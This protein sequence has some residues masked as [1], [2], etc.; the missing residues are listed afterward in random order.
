MSERNQVR[1]NSHE[2]ADKAH[3]FRYM[4][5]RG[6]VNK[7]EKVLDAGCGTGYGSYILSQ[8]A[9]SVFCID[10][11][12][13]FDKQYAKDNITFLL[14]SLDKVEKEDIELFGPDVTVCFEAI[15]H[16]ESPKI[17][18]D[19]VTA[20]TKRM[21]IFSSPDKPTKHE[22]H[23]HKHDILMTTFQEM[24][25][26]Y[27]EWELYHGIHQ[28]YIWINIYIKKTENLL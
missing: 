5:A 3:V 14:E 19:K 21:M 27:P 25:S 23:W 4:L 28:G 1:I 16:L 15:E 8:V 26:D 2:G 6:F 20:T 24:M 10:Y 9:D 17:F 12:D 11:K 7:G 22:H 13:T 18:L